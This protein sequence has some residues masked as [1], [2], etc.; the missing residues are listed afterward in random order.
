[1]AGRSAADSGRYILSIDLGTSGCKVALVSL[2]GVIAGWAFRPVPM[3]VVDEIGAEQRPDEWWRAFVEAS[4]EVLATSGVSPSAVLSVCASTQGEGT[5]PVDRD[6]RPLMNAILWLDMRGAPHVRRMMRGPLKLAG[7][8]A[9]KLQRWLRLCG[10]APALSGK[11]PFGHMLFV[12]DELPAIYERTYK[13]LNVLDYFLL[14]LTGRFIATQD[15]ILTSWVTDNRD[16][17]NIR[18]DERLIRLAGIERDKLPDL[19]RCTDDVGSLLPAVAGE[20][21]LPA[22]VRVVAGSIDTSAAALGAGTAGDFDSHLYVGSSSWI[23]AHVPFKKVNVLSQI[24]SV[25]SA[26][27]SRYLMIAMQTS[28]ANNIAFLK[29]RIIF[30][31]DGLIDSEPLPDVYE[32][33]DAIAARMKPGADGLMYLPWLFG[34]R[35]PVDDKALRAGLFNLSMGHNRET[36]VRAVF[37][38]TALNT[39]WMKKPVERFLRRSLSQLSIIGGGALSATWCQIFADVLDVPI[40]RSRDPLRANALGAA[41]IAAAG[42]GVA[43]FEDSARWVVTDRVYQP[44]RRLK[45]LYDERF[46]LFLELHR[47]LAPIYRRLNGEGGSAD[48]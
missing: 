28:S 31:D 20:L 5:I 21:G 39:R 9:F 43:G 36:L 30:H 29:D 7:Y 47:K 3:I 16:I 42:L 23:A 37:E 1:M 44:D 38:G 33:L 4:R 48:A 41:M 17:A 18:Y 2:T 6:G 25:P 11:D 13:F 10:G 12:R 46:G 34:E 14:R 8:D 40:R 27:P 22:D 35:C 32:A 24:A 15:S 26:L 45:A 19:V